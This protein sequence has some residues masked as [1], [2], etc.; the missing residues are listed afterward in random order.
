[1]IAVPKPS[2]IEERALLAQGYVIVAGVDEVGS[3]C[4]AGPV[5]A[6][7]VILPFDSRIGLIRDSK[8][9]S[10]DQRNRV[11][12]EIKQV[13]SAWAVGTASVEEIDEFNIRRA[14]L[15]AMRRA[16]RGLKLEPQ[17]VI[18]DA[19]EI[20]DLLIPQ[21]GI[22][23][24]D[25]KVKSVA[26]ASV[27]AKVERDRF[28]MEMDRQYPGYGFTEHKGYGTKV[29]KEALARFG[30]CPI[31]RKNFAPVKDMLVIANGLLGSLE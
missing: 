28:M 15:L 7:A 12:D 6:G 13:A 1:M 29:H 10:A 3:G 26:A 14:G 27:I 20:P 4:L 11:A 24:A 21:K 23:A 30:P 22:V 8:T 25:R 16:V 31:H 18:V 9:L 2:F 17:F 5:Y 19:F